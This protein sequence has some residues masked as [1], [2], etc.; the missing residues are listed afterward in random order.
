MKFQ[1]PKGP[2]LGS[3]TETTGLYWRFF[4]RPYCFSFANAKRETAVIS[5]DVDPFTRTVKYD[6]RLDLLRDIYQDVS[7]AKTFHNASFDIGMIESTGIKVRGEVVDTMNLIRLTMPGAPVKLK[8]FCR[9]YLNIPTDD[10]TELK[11]ATRLARLHGE[12]KGWKVFHSRNGNKKKDD[13]EIAADYW[14]AGKELYEPYCIM[15]SIR[16]ISVCQA[17]WPGIKGMGIEKLWANEQETFKVLRD[18]E[19]RGI[20]ILKEKVEE[21][22]ESV[23]KK[24]QMYQIKA[25]QKIRL[26]LFIQSKKK[27]KKLTKHTEINLNSSQQLSTI[28]YERFKEPIIYFTKKGN[29]STDNSALSLMK[30]PI[31]KD[32]L[33]IKAC[34]KTLQ[35]MDQYRHFMVQH[36]DR[37]WYIHPILHQAMTV[38]GRESCSDPNLQ[39]VA[40][41]EK[42]TKIEVRVEARSVFGPRRNYALRSYD[43]KNIEVYIPG[44]ASNDKKI[45]A[46]L[47]NG[48]DVHEHTARQLTKRTKTHIGRFEAKRTFFGLQYGIG[49]KKLSKTL[50]IDIEL[51]ARVI[52][53]IKNEY[54]ELFGFLDRLI[55]QAR[56]HGYITTMYGRKIPVPH[57]DAYKAPNYF[58]QGTAGGILKFA[59][60]KVHNALR[61]KDAF[62]AL[63]VHDELLIEIGRT[64][65]MGLIDKVVVDCMQDNPELN[66][67]VKIPV[68][69]SAIGANWAEKTKVASL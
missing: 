62:I 5:F 6:D 64:T 40:S 4:D 21:N 19:K 27:I 42:E 51:A 37:D 61:K 69:I 30:C 45:T 63:P 25:L 32:I 20:R 41:G 10:E 14:M 54:P 39:Q 8:P 18:V 65:D 53:E 34:E 12:K 38:T 67:P 26:P 52:F 17:L 55:M 22:T 68:S 50:G 49:P 9:N 13:S 35:F 47:R 59:K 24:L 48:E 57:Q 46:L 56:K 16:T 7:I 29:P 23:K 31:A 1:I 66:M 43:W 28:F 2:I 15:D 33:N 3:D 60:V 44:F 11:E 36:K 58:V